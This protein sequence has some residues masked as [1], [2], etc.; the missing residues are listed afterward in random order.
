MSLSSMV[1]RRSEA[2][3]GDRPRAAMC[4]RRTIHRGHCLAFAAHIGNFLEQ[5]VFLMALTRQSVD[6]T[7]PA[8][9]AVSLRP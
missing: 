3:G 6:V 2:V 4:C 1:L 8:L 7:P 9:T 5:E